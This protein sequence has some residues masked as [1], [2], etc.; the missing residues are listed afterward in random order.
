MGLFNFIQSVFL[1]SALAVCLY[2]NHFSNHEA[3]LV[4]SERARQSQTRAHYRLVD[5]LE[6]PADNRLESSSQKTDIHKG[7]KCIIAP[8]SRFDCARDRLLSQSQCEERG[9]CYSP[10]PSSAGPPWC[11]YPTVYP[12]Y[13]MGPLTPTK[14]GQAATL[15]RAHASYLPKDI[16]TL[17]LEVSEEA[18]GCLHLTVS[19]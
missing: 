17:S 15:T 11:F 19:I 5:N 10:L 6:Q 13:E 8:Q 1:A 7:D 16:S 9:C 18:P 12:G 2:M 3:R 4:R 14:R